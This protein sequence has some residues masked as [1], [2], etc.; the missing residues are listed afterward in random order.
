MTSTQH[1]KRWL[2]GI[3][4]ND[5]AKIAA[6][7]VLI[8]QGFAKNEAVLGVSLYQDGLKI[9]R[10]HIRWLVS[11]AKSHI[12]HIRDDMSI[13]TDLYKGTAYFWA[14]KYRFWMRGDAHGNGYKGIPIEKARRIIHQRF[15]D[16][17][18]VLHGET[19]RH[20]EIIN[21]VFGMN[22]YGKGGE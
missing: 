18:L 9:T 10:Q 17:G 22:D 3:P 5:P 8:E 7:M 14:H 20:D 4:S 13:G 19:Q 2:P 16:E 11:A 21:E 1:V 6:E 12:Y 15:L